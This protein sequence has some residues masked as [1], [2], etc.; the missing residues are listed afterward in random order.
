MKLLLLT[1]FTLTLTSPK[2]Q[3]PIAP[4]QEFFTY[5]YKTQ[6]KPEAK[7]IYEKG[8]NTNQIQQFAPKL[9]TLISWLFK[10]KMLEK[11]DTLILTSEEKQHLVKALQ[12]KSDTSIWKHIQFPNS[13]EIAHDS[14]SAILKDKTRGWDYIYK[15]YGR[16]IYTLGLPIFFRN[17]Q[18]CLL[19]YG[20]SCGE[21]CS[22]SRFELYIKVSGV[23]VKGTIIYEGYS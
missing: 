16:Q 14:V 2:A 19:Y 6:N 18:Y 13:I 8:I 21:S 10:D 12:N 7:F 5:F 1:I 9:D 4:T 11:V 17:N 15:N 22:E 3:T 20:K 23:W